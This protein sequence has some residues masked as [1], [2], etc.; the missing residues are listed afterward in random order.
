MTEAEFIT[1]FR[2]LD[3]DGKDTVLTV[4]EREYHWTIKNRLEELNH[5]NSE[6]QQKPIA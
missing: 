1:K 3:D 4:L 2:V 6:N 5:G